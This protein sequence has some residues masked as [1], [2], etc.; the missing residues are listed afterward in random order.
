[1]KRI[2]IFCDGTWNN[3]DRTDNDTS[4]ARLFE[5]VKAHQTASDG[6]AQI[7]HY[8]PGVGVNEG[9]KGFRKKADALIGG[10]LGRGLTH[11]I[12]SCYAFIFANHEPGDEIFIFGFSRGA[13]TARSLAGLLRAA[14]VP[15]QASD[16]D[17]A[18]SWYRSRADITHPRSVESHEF[19][20]RISPSVYTNDAEKAWRI[21][22]GIAPG[23]QLNIS[24]VGVFDTVGAHGVGGILGQFRLVPGGHGFHDHELSSSVQAARH[25]IGL[26]ETRVLYR[27]TQWA[28]VGE[29]N[30]K[31]GTFAPSDAPFQQLWFPGSHGKI[32]GSG[33]DRRISNSVMDWIVAGAASKGLDVPIPDVLQS[34]P[35]DFA[36]PLH[37]DS[38]GIDVTGALRWRR[39]GPGPTEGDLLHEMSELRLVAEPGYRPASLQKYLLDGFKVAE[40]REKHATRFA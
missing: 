4:V 28:N 15:S 38:S 11:D 31:A 30:D 17:E 37:N 19:R 18:L 34:K 33:T 25:A 16:L 32:G 5:V 9:L 26:D 8:E 3:K 14:A 23:E 22:Q 13:Y 21:E 6:V 24:Y 40:L 27:P 20:A 7:A 10:A 35:D 36:G 2:A 1:M 39:R 29:L 12:A